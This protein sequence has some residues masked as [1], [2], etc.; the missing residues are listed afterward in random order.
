MDV[1]YGLSFPLDL[2]QTPRFS[3]VVDVATNCIM[4]S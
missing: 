2:P 4:P 3:Q 1:D